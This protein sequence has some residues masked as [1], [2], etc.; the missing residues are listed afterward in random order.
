MLCEWSRSLDNIRLSDD[1][2]LRGA[3]AHAFQTVVQIH[4]CDD[5]ARYDYAY[6]RPALALGASPSQGAEEGGT[7]VTVKTAFD[8]NDMGG[9]SCVGSAIQQ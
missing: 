2:T 8:E 4:V 9:T 7:I 3:H 1:I 6:F 5:V